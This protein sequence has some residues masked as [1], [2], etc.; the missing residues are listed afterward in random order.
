MTT[1]PG[2]APPLWKFNVWDEDVAK[3]LDGQMGKRVVLHYRELRFV[4][5][6][7][8]ARPGPH[9][10]GSGAVV[11]FTSGVETPLHPAREG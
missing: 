4:P 6:S 7:E 11:P 8:V 9:I 5:T 3:K 1:V 2:V 10:S